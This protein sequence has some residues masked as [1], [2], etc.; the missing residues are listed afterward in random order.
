MIVLY[1][2]TGEDGAAG[3]E[4]GEGGVQA[5]ADDEAAR[6]GDERKPLAVGDAHEAGDGALLCRACVC[7]CV[8]GGSG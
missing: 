4:D 7:V 6:G 2:R 3:R 1:I 5:V 8:W